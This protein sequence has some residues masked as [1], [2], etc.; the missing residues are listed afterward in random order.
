MFHGEQT[1]QKGRSERL[2]NGIDLFWVELSFQGLTKYNNKMTIT[3]HD[4]SKT[5]HDHYQQSIQKLTTTVPQF[6]SSS[7]RCITS[8]PQVY[9][10]IQLHT[11]SITVFSFQNIPSRCNLWIIKLLEP[12]CSPL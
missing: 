11:P 7:F 10:I 4:K 2:K 3:N 9:S 8:K 5:C 1:H 6:Q 12:I